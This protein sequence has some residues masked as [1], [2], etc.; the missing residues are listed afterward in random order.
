MGGDRRLADGTGDRGMTPVVGIVLL[1]AITLLLAATVAAFALGIEEDRQPDPLPT[2]AVGFEYDRS[3][4]MDDVLTIVHKSGASVGAARIAVVVED[5][6]CLG[7]PTDPDGRYRLDPDF[8]ISG[9]IS[10]GM[11]VDVGGGA[12]VTCPAGENLDLS[13]GTVEVA[14]VSESG[15]STLLRS[16]HGPD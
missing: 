13:A 10:S 2:V 5:A 11:S 14:W 8:S 6:Q 7:G 9:P 16:W 12:P 1:V 3:A 15:S 4:G